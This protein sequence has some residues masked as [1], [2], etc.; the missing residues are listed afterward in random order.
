ME[1]LTEVL[2]EAIAAGTWTQAVLSQPRKG[3]GATADKVKIK[4]VLLKNGLHYQF[5]HYTG[6]KVLHENVAPEQTAARAEELLHAQY[7]QGLLQTSE[8]DYHILFN[9]KDEAAVL[10]KKA[11]KTSVELAHNRKKRYVLEE[12]TPVPFLIELGVMNGQGKVLAAKYDKFRQ[13]NR[14]LEMI[15][16][17]VPHLPGGRTVR[18]VDFGCGKSYLTFALY[19]YLREVRKLDLQVVGLDLKEDVIRHCNDLA[20][21]LGYDRLRFLVGDISRYDGMDAVDMVV[22]LHACDTATDA[23]I[24][25]AVRWGAGVILSVP[26]CQHELFGQIR[27]EAMSPLLKHGI[28]KERFASLV[29]DAARAQLLELLGYKTQVL[30]FIDMEHTP[31]NLLIRAV[32]EP[33]KGRP[34][35]GKE[36]ASVSRDPL[37]VEAAAYRGFTGM[38]GISPYLE[39]ALADKLAP[40][41]TV[42]TS[43]NEL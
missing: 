9:K 31:K 35:G 3:G 15:D 2:R 27:N 6:T 26:C 28:L 12:G 19:H 7:K 21:R 16:D 11:T 30:E 18:I 17:V 4:P 8:A 22:T 1:S 39:R 10:K 23:A 29:T 25:K 33:G 37:S 32:K 36:Q 20:E 42:P 40:Q 24:E 41:L 43:E 14:F 13:I 5:A 34:D 38:L